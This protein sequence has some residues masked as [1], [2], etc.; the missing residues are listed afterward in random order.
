MV[1]LGFGTLRSWA[2]RFGDWA[3]LYNAPQGLTCFPRAAGGIG[4]L[5]EVG[6]VFLN[7]IHPSFLGSG[8]RVPG[9]VGNCSTTWLSDAK[10]CRSFSGGVKVASVL[11][12]CQTLEWSDIVA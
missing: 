1:W 11:R 8:L 5:S 10:S 9:I 2:L 4:E 12:R 7:P 3:W 6:F